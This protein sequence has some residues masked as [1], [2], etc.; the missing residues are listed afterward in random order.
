VVTGASGGIGAAVAMVAARDGWDV[1]LTYSS[2]RAAADEVAERVRSHGR[3]SLVVAADVAREADVLALFAAV[4]DAWGGLD[5]LVNN[6]GIAPGYGTFDDLQAADVER[7]L[8]VNVTGAI[9]CA[10]E[11]VRRMATDRGGSGGSIVNVGSKASVLGGPGEW[12]HYAASKGAVDTLTVGLAKEAAARGI[13]VNAVR[14]GLIEGGFGPWAPPERVEA[15]RPGVP[16]QRAARPDEIA[17]A[18]VW[19]ASDQASY[20]TGA[21]L[22]V[23]GGR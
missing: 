19:L 14:P 6:A 20:V 18:I 17:E 11:A 5:C 2:R 15:M 21:I 4:D 1:C 22:D 3:R 12:I 16:I 7:T 23:T 13:R 9:L 10:R 8:A